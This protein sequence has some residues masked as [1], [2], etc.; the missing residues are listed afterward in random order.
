ML[1]DG[2]D[3]D[4]EAP[5]QMSDD[6]LLKIL[7]QEEQAAVLFQTS[8]LQ[9][10]RVKSFEYYN[11]EPYGDEQEG[12]SQVVTSEFADTVESIMPSLMRIFAGSDQAVDFIPQAPG[13]EKFAREASAY[14][15]HVLM[16]E[17]D[18]FRV[19][20]DFLKDALM[21][22]TGGATID[23]DDK[24]ETKA[25]P[26]EGIT[27]D[28][29][30]IMVAEADSRGEEL[31]LDLVDDGTGMLSGTATITRKRKRVVIDGIAPE[32][33]LFSPRAR[34]I[35]DASYVGFRK[36]VRAS[37]LVE[38]GMSH[39]D[40]EELRSDYVVTIEENQRQSGAIAV[41]NQ[42]TDDDDS[43]RPLWLV[44]CFVKADYNGD[45][46][47]EMLR[48]VYAHAGATPSKLVEVAEWEGDASVTI[49]TPILM[50]HNIVGMSIF[51]QVRDLQLI[52]SVL[53]RGMLDNLYMV[54]R[55][56]PVISDQ[57]NLDS[58]I[59]WVPGSPVR[60]KAGARPQDGH[61]SWLTVPDVG[62]STLASLEYLNTVR[63]NRT[64]VVRNNQGLSA[65]TLNKTAA[66][67]G[68][69]MNAAQTRQELIAR[70]FAETSVKRLYRLIYR[71]V[72]KAAQGPVQWWTGQAFQEVDPTQW[73]D[74]LDLIV[75][76][77]AGTR[78]QA[79][80]GLTMVTAA[81]EKLITLQ[82]GHA[83]GPYVTPEN[84][85]N[86][87]QRLAEALGF[88]ST[89]T[90]FQ[91]PEKVAQAVAQQAQQPPQPDPAMAKVQAE[92]AAKQAQQQADAQLAQQKAQA[93][94]ALAREKA[95]AEIDIIRQ[96]AAI[97]AQIKREAAQ[98]DAQLK[99]EELQL[100]ADLK[101]MALTA[102]HVRQANSTQIQEQEVS[103]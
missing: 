6:D 93:E 1:N 34:D 99:R 24:I 22:R 41:Q 5:E 40:V 64:G 80:Q 97:E 35:D 42:R 12:S 70:V 100:E 65:D 54:N 85:A 51:D 84:I 66:G 67:M 21:Y 43:E 83:N 98:L 76:V 59:D 15:P 19:L 78:D 101:A 87:A 88:R 28:A 20:H 31:A 71:A 8:T 58:L 45:G 23:L 48:V 62:P 94:M 49:G 103:T 96:K 86:T 38:M 95:A 9:E 26:V 89:T 32:D 47:S 82:G 57:V 10:H 56:R 29:V 81:Q 30:N 60:L 18:G 17:N 69:L 4:D 90:F 102:D 37:D 61:V 3:R 7:R 52:S 11:R 2:R 68:M 36:Q 16:R 25:V 27:A 92:M 33:I 55:P 77:G 50:P 13:Q 39:E 72:K 75:N 14:I 53:T 74:D 46:V 73:P 44:V 79:L 63:E 91:P